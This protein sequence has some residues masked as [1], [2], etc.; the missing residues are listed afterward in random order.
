MTK[1]IS[2]NVKRRLKVFGPIVLVVLLFCTTS[3]F[4]YF[5]GI[6]KL[7]Q[8][9]QALKQELKELKA[10]EKNLKEE[11]AKL[12]DPDYIAKY[13]RENYYYTKN[14]EYVIKINDE[15][16][17]EEKVVQKNKSKVYYIIG[18]IV[19]ILNILIFILLKTGKNKKDN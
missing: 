19:I 12:K 17:T 8:E 13:A 11:I 9:E 7:K 14:G 6:Y 10:N 15:D 3:I 5:Y 4:S 2:R 16:K 1:K 18:L